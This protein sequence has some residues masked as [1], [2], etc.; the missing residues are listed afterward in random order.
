MMETKEEIEAFLKR[1]ITIQFESGTFQKVVY[2]S[3]FNLTADLLKDWAKNLRLCRNYF[4][5]I[6]ELQNDLD[7]QKTIREAQSQTI[8][9][10][11]EENN[12]LRSRNDTAN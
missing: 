3:G 5:K 2:I 9:K 11:H 1:N 4:E 6:K 12:F 8:R 10:L 7:L